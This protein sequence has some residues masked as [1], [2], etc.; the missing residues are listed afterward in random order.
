MLK[1]ADLVPAVLDYFQITLVLLLDVTSKHYLHLG[2][3]W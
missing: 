2:T 1:A 3:N